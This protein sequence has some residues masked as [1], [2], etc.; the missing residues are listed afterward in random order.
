MKTNQHIDV[1][2]A[3]KKLELSADQI[4]SVQIHLQATN[5]EGDIIDSAKLPIG[6]MDIRMV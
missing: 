3:V 2:E 4:Q 5:K 6:S 1:S